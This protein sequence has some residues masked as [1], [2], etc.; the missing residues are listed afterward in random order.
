MGSQK[1]RH[2]EKER[3]IRSNQ[4]INEDMIKTPKNK[5]KIQNSTNF[6]IREMKLRAREVVQVEEQSNLL[7]GLWGFVCLVVSP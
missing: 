1:K 3:K 2:E 7:K 6:W 5:I 4:P